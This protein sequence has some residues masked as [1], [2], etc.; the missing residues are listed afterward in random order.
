MVYRPPSTEW[1]SISITESVLETVC[2][3]NVVKECLPGKYRT[4]SGH[5]NNVAKPFWGAAHEPMQRLIKAAYSDG[6]NLNH[7][8]IH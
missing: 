5:C 2:P 7:I 8:T 6:Y 3:L 1:S 4:Y